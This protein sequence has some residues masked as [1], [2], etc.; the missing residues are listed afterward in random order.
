MLIN[1]SQVS[2]SVPV[3]QLHLD[4]NAH[5]PKRQGETRNAYLLPSPE[6]SQ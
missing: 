3:L 1:K 5:K 4:F 6:L 2:H